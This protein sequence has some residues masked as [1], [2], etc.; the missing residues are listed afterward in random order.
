V[1][2]SRIQ[3]P[4]GLVELPVGLVVSLLYRDPR[5]SHP[6]L[7]CPTPVAVDAF[8]ISYITVPGNSNFYTSTRLSPLFEKL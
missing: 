7:L 1:W 6:A 5:L 3:L 4:V 2:F 8:S